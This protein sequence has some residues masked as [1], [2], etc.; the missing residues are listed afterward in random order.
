MKKYIISLL[1]LFTVASCV[2]RE[3][4]KFKLPNVPYAVSGK[5]AAS[6]H[7]FTFPVVPYAE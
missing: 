2:Q 7:E 1:C 4:V 5:A 6:K 3:E